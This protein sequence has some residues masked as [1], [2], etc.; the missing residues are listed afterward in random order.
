MKMKVTKKIGTYPNGYTTK[1]NWQLSKWAHN[2]RKKTAPILNGLPAKK[3][4]QML[5]SC[6]AL[7]P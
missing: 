3:Q 7:I 4:K 1:Q 2:Y 6:L 5:F